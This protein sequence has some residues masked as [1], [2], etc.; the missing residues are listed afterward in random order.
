MRSHGPILALLALLIAAPANAA[1]KL[2]TFKTLCKCAAAI[3]LSPRRP[4]KR[5]VSAGSVELL[6]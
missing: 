6:T 5:F 1:A 4:T 2:D 3:T